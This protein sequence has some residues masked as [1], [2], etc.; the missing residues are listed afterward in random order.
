M[1]CSHLLGVDC[2]TLHRLGAPYDV[3]QFRTQGHS[4]AK[5]S[6]RQDSARPQP[7]RIAAYVLLVGGMVLVVAGMASTGTRLEPAGDGLLL[8]GWP[9]LILG[10]VLK[11]LD[12][13]SSYTA[14]HE[15]SWEHHVDGP[16][17]RGREGPASSRRRSKRLRLF[18]GS[19][20]PSDFGLSVPDVSDLP[21]SR[22]LPARERAA[23]QASVPSSV[24]A[25]A[26]TA[27]PAGAHTAAPTAAFTAEPAPAGVGKP[28]QPLFEPEPEPA[29][30][31]YYRGRADPGPD[32]VIEEFVGYEGQDRMLAVRDAAPPPPPR[33]LAWP[34]PPRT[35]LQVS[36]VGN[37]EFLGKLMDDVMAKLG[38]LEGA[39]GAAAPTP[40][41]GVEPADA[42]H[43]AMP[44]AAPG[45]A[46]SVAPGA[47]PSGHRHPVQGPV[48][49]APL[50]MPPLVWSPR[51][52]HNADHWR[53]AALVEKLYQQ[54]GFA[55]QLQAGQT[56][57]GVVVLWLFSRHRPGMPASVVSCVHAPGAPLPPEEIVAVADLVKTRDLPRGQLAT[58]GQVDDAC[59]QLA[60]ARSVHLMDTER[61][62][63]LITQRSLEQQRVLA[64]RLA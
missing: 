46:P 64:D 44:G 6:G 43:R 5:Q 48:A 33:E 20:Q 51:M 55:T 36:P 11:G 10:C 39:P 32:T 58:T 52:L 42:S 62:L 1:P 22:P 23:S 9:L 63:Q 41:T 18:G 38:T 24:S 14:A 56:M 7:L 17:E 49:P 21:L 28:V 12:W 59:R 37:D 40:S 57:R 34:N 35:A 19:D 60:A 26:P 54:A 13:M 25:T 4:V 50:A 29:E 3:P 2:V 16:P 47:M 27:A 31:S 30:R 15:G 53:F 8:M 61:L 45:A